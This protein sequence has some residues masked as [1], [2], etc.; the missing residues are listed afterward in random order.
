LVFP[1]RQ[2]KYSATISRTL[3]KIE[4]TVSYKL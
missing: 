4:R 1:W 3:G 2:K